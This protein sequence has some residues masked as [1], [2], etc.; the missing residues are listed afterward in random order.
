MTDSQLPA[1]V[2]TFEQRMKDRIK[3]SIG[4]LMSDEDLAKLVH[5]GVEE[6]FF[7]DRVAGQGYNARTSPPLMHEIVG[8][9]M[10][11]QIGALAKEWIKEHEQEV[12][13]IAEKTIQDGA[14]E[15]FLLALKNMFRQEF[16]NLQ[17]GIN[18]RI[19]NL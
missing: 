9:L 6:A 1:P 5:R 4:E 14:G 13:E 15:A 7:T 19:Q 17:Y 2:L 11:E 3:D 10:A 8:D 16:V 18:Q 12:R